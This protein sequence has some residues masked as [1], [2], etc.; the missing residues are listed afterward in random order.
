MTLILVH[1][2][3]AVMF[4]LFGLVMLLAPGAMME[5][6]N[7]GESSVGESILQGMSVMVLGMAYVSWKI[8]NWVGD[9]IKTVGMFFCYFHVAWGLLTI[10]H[11]AN[12]TLPSDTANLVGNLGPDVVLAILFFWKSR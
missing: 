8:P 5:S 1:R 11:M 12:G 3:Q 4:A 9:N 6:F 10:F 2:I 7:V